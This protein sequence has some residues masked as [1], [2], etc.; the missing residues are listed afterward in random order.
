MLLVDQVELLRKNFKQLRNQE[1]TLPLITGGLLAT[2]ETYY[3]K[4]LV[5]PARDIATTIHTAD[6]RGNKLPPYLR[7]WNLKI[8]DEYGRDK[9]IHLKNLLGM[10]IHVYYLNIAG[11]SLDIS[12]DFGNRVIVQYDLFLDAVEQLLLSPK[13]ICLVVCNLAE[14]NLK[15]SNP[16]QALETAV[17]GS[18]DLQHLLF[19]ISNW[20]SLKEKI[21]IKFFENKTKFT[22]PNKF[23]R[24]RIEIVDGNCE[25]IEDTPF[26]SGSHYS[27]TT[28]MW[29]M[30]W[31]RDNVYVTAWIDVS[32]LIYEIRD[33]FDN[34]KRICE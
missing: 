12:N 8:K 19:T 13:D 31:R 17:P 28:T 1:I 32:E 24:N 5:L 14:K 10:I 6:P 4:F 2:R 18:G 29:K 21:W 27:G 16:M 7:H 9:T 25:I 33:H 23:F 34:S 30:R 3:F 11:G 20:P 22:H 26:I 15:N